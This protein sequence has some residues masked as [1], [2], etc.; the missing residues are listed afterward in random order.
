MSKV[1]MALAVLFV[2]CVVLVGFVPAVNAAGSVTWRVWDTNYI[3]DSDGTTNLP[4]D[5]YVQL[6]DVTDPV[7]LNHVLL[8]EA[9]IGYGFFGAGQF[10]AVVNFPPAPTR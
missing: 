5:S 6:W 2:V 4:L 7:R 3:T 1:T 10:S 9:A 8:D